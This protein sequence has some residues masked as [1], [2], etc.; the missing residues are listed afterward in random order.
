[1]NIDD[2][3]ID[4]STAISALRSD[5]SGLLKVGYSGDQNA[6][7]RDQIAGQ[8]IA[9]ELNNLCTPKARGASSLVESLKASQLEELKVRCRYYGASELVNF[10]A[11]RKIPHDELSREEAI[12]YIQDHLYANNFNRIRYFD[13]KKSASFTTYISRVINNLIIDYQRK[14]GVESKYSAISESIL[15][16]VE[17][18][19][20]NGLDEA[21]SSPSQG[22]NNTYNETETEIDTQFMQWIAKALLSEKQNEEHLIPTLSERREN[23]RRLLQISGRERIFLR[24]LCYDDLNIN[25][26]RVLPFFEMNVNEAYQFYRQLMEKVI[27]ALRESGLASEIHALVA[28]KVD[29]LDVYYDNQLIKTYITEILYLAETDKETSKCQARQNGKLQEGIIKQR[30]KKLGKKYYRH[31]IP[32][33]SDLLVADRHVESVQE[34]KS[35]QPHYLIKLKGLNQLFEVGARYVKFLPQVWINS[36]KT[37]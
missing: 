15:S 21:E 17:E 32:I 29:Q 16:E 30:L 19:S 1:M 35:R 18:P 14:K 12:A 3:Q 24:A 5:L 10:L 25:Q 23:L 9:N 2:S 4:A 33:R 8:Y 20:I 36:K 26:I 22:Q 6:S 34:K 11:R 37:E 31:F 27:D 7:L 13:E 28:D